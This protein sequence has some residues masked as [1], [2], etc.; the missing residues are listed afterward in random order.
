MKAF[1]H[2]I[3]NIISIHFFIFVLFSTCF[4]ESDIDSIFRDSYETFQLLRNEKG[5]YRDALR[6]DGNHYHPASVSV[7]GMGLI[8]LCIADRMNWISDA[9]NLA[10][11]T[12]SSMTGNNQPFNP[13]RN[14]KGYFRHWLN[15]NTGQ[16]EWNSEYSSID[17]A[18]LM[19]GALFCQKYF[20]SSV[21]DTYVRDLWN[22][23]DWSAAIADVETGAIYR[24]FNA[25]GSGKSGTLTIP[26]NEY[27]IIAWLAKNA[28]GKVGPATQLWQKFYQTTDNLPTKEYDGKKLVTDG[29]YYLSHFVVQFA[30]YLC[31]HF[32]T[33]S[34][35]LQYMVNAQEADQLW[36]SQQSGISNY[37][38]GLGAGSAESSFGYHAD[39]INDNPEKICSPHIVA[40]F[41]PIY[42]N[43]K[44]NLIS[45]INSELGIYS[46]PA[47]ST[48]KVLWRFKINNIWKPGDIQGI[49]YALM[50]FGLASLPEYLGSEFFKKYNDF[51]STTQGCP[52][53]SGT[54]AILQDIT[55]LSGT[56]C[57][58]NAEEIVFDKNVTVESQA[59]VRV[60][61]KKTVFKQ[62]I[63][64]ENGADFK[65]GQ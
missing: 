43:G 20:K 3:L 16:Q 10:L 31:N 55:F 38:W 61:A 37:I 7:V 49:D 6:F 12:L 39:A 64:I 48:G 33:R 50:L 34:E 15:M 51:F 9:E 52:N 2:F 63:H 29:D 5:V 59:R 30:Y 18:I 28:E 27:M 35:Y 1:K 41:L 57:E 47:P 53:C 44:D 45:L 60:K 32:T 54:I 36:W 56:D 13:D 62:L 25:D 24:E 46:L 22:S 26:F 8:S 11:I 23:I 58:C 19:C 14:S 40:G 21:I 17:T 4:S 65:A 42:Q